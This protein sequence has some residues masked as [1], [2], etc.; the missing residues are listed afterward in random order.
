MPVTWCP[1]Q[2]SLEESSCPTELLPSGEIIWVTYPYLKCWDPEGLWSQI[3]TDLGYLNVR[4]GTCPHPTWP[5]VWFV[6]WPW[7]QVSSFRFGSVCSLPGAP[8]RAEQMQDTYTHVLAQPRHSW[9]RGMGSASVHCSWSMSR[10]LRML[11]PSRACPLP[12]GLWRLAKGTLLNRTSDPEVYDTLVRDMP[13]A[14]GTRVSQCALH[15]ASP[16]TQAPPRVNPEAGDWTGYLSCGSP[17]P[18]ECQPLLSPGLLLSLRGL[19]Q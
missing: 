2:R 15:A 14:R 11:P 8:F 5:K 10:D 19:R 17:R 16:I 4:H 13:A 3:S 9:S 18:W 7:G 12:A 6:L 1:K